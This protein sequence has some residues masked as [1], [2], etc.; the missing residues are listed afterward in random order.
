M[1]S[2]IQFYNQDA[3]FPVCKLDTLTYG[4]TFDSK[5]MAD[6]VPEGIEIPNL[7]GYFKVSDKLITKLPEITYIIKKKDKD[8]T[9]H[10]SNAMGTISFKFLEKENK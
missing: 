5:K 6:L 3:K 1:G 4:T 2:L 9:E 10:K 7:G 8:N